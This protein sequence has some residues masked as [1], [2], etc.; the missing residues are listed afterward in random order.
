MIGPDV[1]S[2]RGDRRPER[3]I[4]RHVRDLLRSEVRPHAVSSIKTVNRVA[5][6]LD[7]VAICSHNADL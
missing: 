7:T 3:R 6:V 5:A 1:P 4:S 2:I